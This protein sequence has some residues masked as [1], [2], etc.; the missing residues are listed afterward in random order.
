MFTIQSMIVAIAFAVFAMI[1]VYKFGIEKYVSNAYKKTA[2]KVS[3]VVMTTASCAYFIDA[4]L[5]LMIISCAIA[6]GFLKKTFFMDL[7]H[8]NN[9]QNYVEGTI[10]LAVFSFVGLMVYQD[11]RFG[12]A[13]IILLIIAAFL[14]IRNEEVKE[15]QATE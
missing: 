5:G 4:Q 12:W 1:I 9:N 8:P 14:N 11:F 3:A 15:I 7:Y 2:I 6:F 13:A 10:S